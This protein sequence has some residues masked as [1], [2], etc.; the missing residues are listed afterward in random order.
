MNITDKFKLWYK[1]K[2]TGNMEEYKSYKKGKTI[3]K[4]KS[5]LQ[6]K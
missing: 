4:T 6:K 1:Y 5:V 3:R 2:L